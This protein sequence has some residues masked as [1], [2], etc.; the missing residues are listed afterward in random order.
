MAVVFIG[1]VPHQVR[2]GRRAFRL[3]QHIQEKGECLHT[4]NPRGHHTGSRD[5]EFFYIR[6]LDVCGQPIVFVRLFFFPE[7]SR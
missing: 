6:S 5:K 7:D 2:Q 4:L 1:D 3:R